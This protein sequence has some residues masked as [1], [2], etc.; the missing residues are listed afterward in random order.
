MDD[1]GVALDFCNLV[2][3]RLHDYKFTWNN[4]RPRA[5]NTRERLDR[6]VANMEWRDKFSTSTVTHM[7]SHAS[8]H[9]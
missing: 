9:L 2:D 3:L 1:L 8:D 5:E 6:A 4:K 7:F